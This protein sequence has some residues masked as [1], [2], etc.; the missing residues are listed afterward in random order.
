MRHFTQQTTHCRTIEPDFT[1]M[2]LPNCLNKH[3]A[4][5][6]FQ[7]DAHRAKPYSLPMNLGVFDTSDDQDAG[8][9]CLFAEFSNKAERN[10]AARVKIQQDYVRRLAFRFFERFSRTVRNT[11][12]L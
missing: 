12:D 2:D 9:L 11:D 8:S 5:I 10:F 7:Y 4:G 3:I 6:L 1:G